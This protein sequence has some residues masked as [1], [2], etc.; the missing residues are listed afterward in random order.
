MD[1]SLSLRV[2]IAEVSKW[3]TAS[4]GTLL[5]ALRN[6]NVVDGPNTKIGDSI[7]L[8]YLEEPQWS[9]S[10]EINMSSKQNYYCAYATDYSFDSRTG[11]Y[12]FSNVKVGKY[13]DIYDKLINNYLIEDCDENEEKVNKL[14]DSTVT[15][16]SLVQNAN[17]SSYEIL[18]KWRIVD[19]VDSSIGITYDDYGMSYY[20]RGNVHKNYVNYA[21]MCFRIVRVQGDGTIKLILDDKDNLCDSEA[22]LNSD[23]AM[24]IDEN[25]MKY[26]ESN[27]LNYSVSNIPSILNDWMYGNDPVNTSELVRNDWCNGEHLE[28]KTSLKC[29]GKLNNVNEYIGL[30]TVDEVLYAGACENCSE[31]VNN[32]L[33]ERV[34]ESFW[35]MSHYNNEQIYKTDGGSISSSSIENTYF[36]RPVIVL[37]SG[38]LVTYAD[39]DSNGSP[40]TRKNPYVIG[41]KTDNKTDNETDNKTV[42]IRYDARYPDVTNVPESESIDVGSDYTLS[43]LV[44]EKGELYTFVGW[45]MSRSCDENLSATMPVG[46]ILQNVQTDITLY[47]CWIIQTG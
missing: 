1:A 14:K 16:I 2:N 11:L 10:K 25:P 5:Y 31:H 43:S 19:E 41:K 3:D 42:T 26:T 36:I 45:N 29:K 35:T 13:I 21:G 34:K 33:S 8:S 17:M 20:F 44:P 40:G 39:I 32:Y 7:A 6:Y 24:Y 38:V 9:Q 15:G 23:M 28:G 30:L 12:S 4:E 22:Y 37:N 18:N 27:I 46:S 47:G